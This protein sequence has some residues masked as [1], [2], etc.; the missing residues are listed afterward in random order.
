MDTHA[1]PETT[2]HSVSRMAGG[3]FGTHSAIKLAC[4][5]QSTL[6]AKQQPI[7]PKA[8]SW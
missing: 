6:A 3:L 5:R 2:A 1:L 7:T 8:H 4:S